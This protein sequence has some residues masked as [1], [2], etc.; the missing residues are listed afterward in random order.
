MM[1]L[2]EQQMDMHHADQTTTYTPATLAELSKLTGRQIKEW[3][4]PNNVAFRIDG[5]ALGDAMPGSPIIAALIDC[6]KQLTA[7]SIHL[8]LCNLGKNFRTT[9]RISRIDTLLTIED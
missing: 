1:K 4:P 8:S 5:T 3:L 7:Q 2:R 9:L 6:Y